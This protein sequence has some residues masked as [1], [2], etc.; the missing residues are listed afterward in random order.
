[1]YKFCFYAFIK[2]E[3]EMK[4]KHNLKQLPTSKWNDNNNNQKYMQKKCP[5]LSGGLQPRL[6]QQTSPH[7]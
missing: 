7:I 2:T 4:I 5:R 6:T 3:S 1:M